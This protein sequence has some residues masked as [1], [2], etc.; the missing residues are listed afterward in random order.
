MS[1]EN[2]EFDG[3]CAFAMSVGGAKHAPDAKPRY[4]VTKN[5]KTYGFVG[6]VPKALFQLIPGSAER[7]DAAWAKAHGPA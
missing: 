6:A 4:T 7:A 2:L 1:N 5:G 3:K